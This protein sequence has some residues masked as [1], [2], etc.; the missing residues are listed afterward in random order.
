ML[1][2]NDLASKRLNYLLIIKEPRKKHLIL[3][4][5]MLTSMQPWHR[6]SQ[7]Q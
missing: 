3:V 7:V 5:L 6:G 2:R 4:L 1:S